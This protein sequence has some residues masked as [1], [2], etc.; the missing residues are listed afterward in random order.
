[1]QEGS[2]PLLPF[3]LS[4][5]NIDDRSGEVQDGGNQNDDLQ[6]LVLVAVFLLG[7]DNGSRL[8]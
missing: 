7:P 2:S 1:M 4:F 5:D 8:I 6:A 3:E